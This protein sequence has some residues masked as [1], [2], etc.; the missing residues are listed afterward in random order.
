[1]SKEKENLE[2]QKELLKLEEKKANT[3]K[4]IIIIVSIVF[5]VFLGYIISRFIIASRMNW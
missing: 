5:I 1:L 2:I 3:R 4:T